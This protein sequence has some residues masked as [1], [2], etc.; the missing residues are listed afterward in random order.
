MTT[1]ALN[2]CL[3]VTK[4]ARLIPPPTISYEDISED[5]DE[6]LVYNDHEH[7]LL[8]EPN[9]WNQLE[10]LDPLNDING[11]NGLS[12]SRKLKRLNGSNVLNYLNDVEMISGDDIPKQI[13]KN[14]PTLTRNQRKNRK[15]NE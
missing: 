13:I 3:S 9:S 12:D 6:Y 11:P 8:D 10:D 1:Y 7:A 15:R 5:E 2:D 4:L 14:T